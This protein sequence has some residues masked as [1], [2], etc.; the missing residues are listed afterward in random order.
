M[1][2]GDTDDYTEN[3]MRFVPNSKPPFNRTHSQ[4]SQ[5][6]YEDVFLA[7]TAVIHV[8]PDA[9]KLQLPHLTVAIAETRRGLNAPVDMSK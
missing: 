8:V 2:G 7:A 6:L 9:L 4:P 5:P 1:L 3:W